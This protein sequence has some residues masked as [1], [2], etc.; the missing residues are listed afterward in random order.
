MKPILL[1]VSF[2][3]VIHLNSFG[4]LT[5][6]ELKILSKIEAIEEGRQVPDLR[7]PDLNG[8]SVALSSLKGKNVYLIFWA[9]WCLPCIKSM[10]FYDSLARELASSNIQFV[11]VSIDA[12]VDKSKQF[13]K[14]KDLRGLK[15][16]A[17]GSKKQPVSYFIY[18]VRWKENNQRDIDNGIPRDV[19]INKEGVIVKN[20]LEKYSQEDIKQLLARIVL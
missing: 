1:S 18:R 4:Q 2:L 12:D 10:S 15:L 20:D 7:L 6:E 13:I 14:E 5:T 9:T 3:V 8:D 11:Y 16:F 19:L 17:G